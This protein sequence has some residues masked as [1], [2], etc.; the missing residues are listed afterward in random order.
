MHMSDRNNG[1][2]ESGWTVAGEADGWRLDR[3]AG[4]WMPES[5]LRGRRRLI[6]SGRLLVDGRQRQPGYRVRAG[7]RL[8]LVAA[9]VPKTV[10]EAADV[11]IVADAGRYAAVAKPPGLH[12]ASIAQS[13]AQ[14]LEGLLPELFPGRDARLLSRL[15]R[16]T[17]GLVPVA[18]TASEADRYREFEN[19]GRV[20]KTYLAVVHGRLDGPRGIDLELDTA[21]RA[22]TRVLDRPSRD[23]RR[24]TEA[25]PVAVDG[26]VTL[27]RC[28]IAKGARHQIR[29]H[30]AAAGHPLV[31]DPLYGKGEGTGLFL[32]CAGLVCPELEA[33]CDP[34]WELA[35]ARRIFEKEAQDGTLTP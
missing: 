23:P 8:Q 33:A 3:A 28:R 19:A 9:E 6:E 20:V 12:S 11:P 15:D 30:M 24:R 1:P 31:G 32:H 21:N 22:I 27:V 26:P 34:P 7:Q 14:S 35:Q 18:F 5:G 13:A 2:E 16:L 4:L 29:A 17:S 10:F 25:E